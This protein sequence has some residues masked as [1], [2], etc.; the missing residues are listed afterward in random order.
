MIYKAYRDDT[1]LITTEDK[2]AAFR[3]LRESE[4]P[5]WR[6]YADADGE[7]EE[8]YLIHRE[9]GR[10][11]PLKRK[12]TAHSQPKAYKDGKIKII[13]PAFSPD[14]YDTIK[15]EADADKTPV[16]TWAKKKLIEC[17]KKCKNC[18]A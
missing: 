15:A 4:K 3:Y 8:Y 9:D 12:T 16:T 5:G 11:S 14:E 13:S 17:A 10:I 6:D 2:R 1:L 18:L 7:K